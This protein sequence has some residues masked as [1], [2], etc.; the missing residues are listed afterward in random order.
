MKNVSWFVMDI[1]GTLTDGTL[2]Y[3]SD[4]VDRKRFHAADGLGIVM[5]RAS[6]LRIAAISGRVSASAHKRLTELKADRIFEGVGDKAAV[7]RSL[8]ADEG[9]AAEQVAYIGDDIN[10]LPAFDVAGVRFAVADASEHLKERADHV[11]V[12]CG[13]RGA[14][15]EAIESIL[16]A[17]GRLGEAIEAYLS[18]GRAGPRQ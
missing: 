14:V 16:E 6:G 12:H 3:S 18:A 17:Q 15:R 10:D 8:L 11:T 1:D 4:G 2:E 5:A 7:L 9:L 13:G